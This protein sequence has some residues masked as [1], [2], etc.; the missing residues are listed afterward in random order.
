MAKSPEDM[1]KGVIKLISLPEIYIRINQVMEDANHN[2]KQVGDVISHD[3]ALTA[4]ILRIVNS[5]YYSLTVKIELVS[6]AV[7]I[8]GEDDLRNLVLATSAVDAFKRIPNELVDIDL[9]WRHSVHTGIIARLLSKHCNILHGERLFVSGL[10]HDIG[11]LILYFKEPELSQQILL[12][13]AES[14]GLLYRA[15]RKI[16]GFSHA[17]VGGA[18]MTSWKMAETLIE[19]VKYHHNPLEAHK[20]PTETAIVHIANCIVN[21]IGPETEVN[22]HLLDDHPGF[23]PETLKITGLDMKILPEVMDKAWE[24]AGEILDII[25][26]RL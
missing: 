26:P 8:I 3:P 15:E 4:R 13:A 22:E 1:V 24:Q 2:A 17:D 14:D 12:E 11:K 7:S 10:L 6:R 23:E 19:V 5:A 20:H 9:F 21:S 18:L 25:C 16:L